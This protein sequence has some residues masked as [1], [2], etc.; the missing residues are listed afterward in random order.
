MLHPK[1]NERKLRLVTELF[2]KGNFIHDPRITSKNNEI[3]LDFDVMQR[4]I[5][6]LIFYEDEISSTISNALGILFKQIYNELASAKKTELEEDANFLNIFF[7]I[8]QLPYLSD[9]V[10]LF[11]VARSFYS[12]FTRLSMDMQVKFVRVLAKQKDHLSAYVAHVQQYITMH[13]VRWSDRTQINS[14]TETLLS[15]EPGRFY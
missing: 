1:V 11:D 15:N 4:S 14:I 9:P 10:F 8:F 5:K 7:I 13:A 2:F 12:L 3:T 6:L